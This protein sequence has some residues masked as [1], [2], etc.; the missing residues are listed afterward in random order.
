MRLRPAAISAALL[1]LAFYGGLI[2]SL[3]YF[4][5]WR[6]FSA[7]LTEP[8]LYHA[9]R[10]SLISAT[11][12]TIFATLIAIPAAYALSRY[13]FPGAGLCDTLLELPVIVSPAALGAMLLIFF[14]SPLGEWIQEN[15]VRFVFTFYGVILAQF[16]ATA[17]IATRFFKSAFDDVPPRYENVART[18]GAGQW[19]VFRTVTLPLAARGLLAGTALTWAK[20]LGEFGATITLAGTM[21]MRTETLPVAIF[22]QLSNARIEETVTL[23]LVLLTLGLGVLAMVRTIGRRKNHADR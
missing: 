15:A 6:Q 17:G 3:F 2:L 4:F 10:L 9:I 22:M 20:A 16:V 19:R 18:M 14:T 8:R 21:A 13:R 11:I 12:A 23:I 7:A 5:E 1:L